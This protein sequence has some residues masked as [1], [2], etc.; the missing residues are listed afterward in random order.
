VYVAGCTEFCTDGQVL[1]IDAGSGHVRARYPLKSTPSGMAI[2]PDGRTLWVAN[3]R[4]ASVSVVDLPSGQIGT[5]RVEPQPM[6]VAADAQGRRVYVASFGS[7]VVVVLDARTRAVLGTIRVG[8]TPRALAVSP[9]GHDL[10][11]THS[12][13][14]VTLVD[15]ARIGL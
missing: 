9:D 5:I 8:Q 12:T 1:T 14:V 10:W 15:L 11:V 3:G 6:G 7:S 13:R 4:E 2:S